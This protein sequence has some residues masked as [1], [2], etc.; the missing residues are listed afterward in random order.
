MGNMGTGNIG[1][2]NM[3]T[4]NMTRNPY[5]TQTAAS[6]P[7]TADT[8]PGTHQQFGAHTGPTFAAVPPPGQP[9]FNEGLSNIADPADPRFAPSTGQKV[10]V[11]NILFIV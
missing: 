4:S 10:A 7:P 1:T 8:M 9:H 2:G 6:H 3:G 5:D 11:C